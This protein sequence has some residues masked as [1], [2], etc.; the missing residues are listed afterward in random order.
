M[1]NEGAMDRMGEAEAL[2][3]ARRGERRIGLE[4][5]IHSAVR[6]LQEQAS[7]VREYRQAEWYAMGNPNGG[8]RKLDPVLASHL[9]LKE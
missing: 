5:G 7:R 8:F 6:A 3:W 1:K 4:H 2:E 9:R